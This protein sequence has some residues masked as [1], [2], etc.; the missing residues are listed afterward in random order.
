MSLAPATH[1][2]LY[3][4]TSLVP[5]W[6]AGLGQA[7]VTMAFFSRRLPQTPDGEPARGYLLWAGLRRALAWLRDARF[8]EARLETLA[9]HPMLGP[10]LKAR[11]DLREALARWRFE[12]VVEAPREGTPLFAG[13]AVDAKGQRV[14]IQDVAP[15]A[16]TPYLQIRTSLLSAKLIETPLLS[17]INHMTMV[18]SKA[19]RVAEAA[20]GRAVLEFGSRRTHP[21]AAVDAAYAAW[22]AGAAGTSNVEAHHR[23]G[24]PV[25]GTMD[26]FAVQAWE[27]PGVPRHVTERAF[28][29]A[30][31]RAYPKGSVLLVDTYDSYGSHTGIRNAVAATGGKLKGIRLDSRISRENIIKARE[32]LDSL[33]AKAATIVVSGGMDEHAIAEL[34]DA[35]VDAF[36]IGERIVTSPD[37]PVGVGAV[38]K[39]A[40]IQGR[41]TMKLARGSGKAT[42]PGRVQVYR[43][44]GVDTVA[45]HD[46]VLPGEPL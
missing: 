23:Y 39:L 20:G 41:M 14:Q 18:A 21:E 15:T 32:L 30:F 16:Y 6:D 17:I 9:A 29:E 26:H 46:E 37:A 7:P 2:D 12:G 40:E 38:G 13:P 4:L 5:H 31:H 11:P 3:Q 1:M 10:A 19:A 45:C 42:L 43:H 36:G 33:G 34:G 28:F 24:V 22:L 27:R 25:L 8:D 44:E 35:P